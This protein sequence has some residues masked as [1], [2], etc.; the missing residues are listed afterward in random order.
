MLFRSRQTHEFAVVV[1]GGNANNLAPMIHGE[2]VK[3]VICCFMGDSYPNPTPNP[4]MQRAY[5]E[6]RVEFE[7]WTMLTLT[8]RLMAG[9]MGL[10]FFPTK[11]MLGSAMTQNN[12]NFHTLNNPFTDDKEG[13]SIGLVRSLNP[14][15]YVTHGAI[16]DEHGNTV[17]Y[18]PYSG[19]VYGAFAAKEGVIVSVERVVSTEEVLQHAE[20]IRIPAAYVKAVV[21]APFGSH[22]SGHSV[23]PNKG[24]GGYGEDREFILQ[25]RRACRS[26][27]MLDQWVNTWVLSCKDQEDY[28]RKL[29]DDRLTSLRGKSQATYWKTKML[30][31]E[32]QCP[33]IEPTDEEK[34]IVIA[35][36]QIKR[37]VQEKRYHSIFPGVGAANLAS[38]L[39]YYM[40]RDEEY[41]VSILAECGMYGYV[42]LPGD[43]YLFAYQNMNTAVMYTDVFHTLGIMVQGPQGNCLGVLGA[44]QID[45]G[46]NIN[47]SKIPQDSLYL[48]GAGGGNDVASAAAEVLIVAKQ[49][50]SRF[51]HHVDY[52]TSPGVRVKTLVTQFG[53]FEKEDNGT[54]CLTGYLSK[55]AQS[56]AQAIAQ[57]KD[58]C[59]WKFAS[60]KNINRLS[61]PTQQ[62]LD[63]L[64]YFDPQRIFL[65]N[66]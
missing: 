45:S 28:L 13:S 65:G 66:V 10:P 48:M 26:K 44:A 55:L 53:V 31:D 9:A 51:P 49:S 25:S 24:G 34:M 7:E 23:L 16:A 3:K 33:D 38:W 36:R 43:P 62:E 37:I 35:A 2:M 54:F 60:K 27:D 50:K 64:R 21:E 56:E 46:G 30:F 6:G 8:L 29:G 58:L 59:G 40:L 32:T 17:I 15:I 4:V 22:P 41:S 18:P 20:H 1:Y 19:N 63:R 57:I 42:P 5:A 11:S 12:A 39:A 61:P 14:D 47:S 52:V